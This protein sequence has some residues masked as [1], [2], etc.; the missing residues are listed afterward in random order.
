MIVLKIKPFRNNITEGPFMNLHPKEIENEAT[1]HIIID[2][3]HLQRI[4]SLLPML[5]QHQ[6]VL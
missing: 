2:T 1:I 4:D 6:A 5:A 3:F